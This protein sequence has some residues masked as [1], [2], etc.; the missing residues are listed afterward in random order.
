M[1]QN[2]ATGGDE[3]FHKYN[4]VIMITKLVLIMNL[5]KKLA[6]REQ[7]SRKIAEVVSMCYDVKWQI[8]IKI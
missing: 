1:V 8:K 4:I 2:K 5:I 6:D 3:I 7:S